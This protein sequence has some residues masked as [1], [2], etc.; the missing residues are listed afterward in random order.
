MLLD[1][2]INFLKDIPPFLFLEP[3]A[4][5]SL[6]AK[7]SLEFY[8]QNTIILKQ[9]GPPSETLLVIKKGGVKV[10]IR[11][12]DGEEVLTDY[13]GEGDLIGYLSLFSGDKSR[14]NVATVED[15][16]CYVISKETIQAL[17]DSEPVI[18][19]FFHKSFVNKYVDKTF[20]EM[21]SKTLMIGGGT[22]TL[23]F[24]T[25]VGELATKGVASVSKEV[26][27]QEAAG[28]M[29]T[30]RIS[31][32]VLT[33]ANTVPV[34][35]LTDRDL[36]DKVVAKGR[37]TSEKVSSIMSPSLIKAE[38]R[39]YCFEALLKMLRHNIHH[40]L[41]VDDG[42]LKGIITN[43]DLMMLQGKSPLSFAKDI[44]SQ[45]T[46]EGLIPVS[47]KV[48]TVVKL[49][50]KEGVRA[51][52]ISKIISELN[53]RVVRKVLEIAEK[54]FGQPPLPYCWIVFGSEGRKEQ[55][56]KTDQ[57]NAIIFA[58]P[59]SPEEKE[60]AKK[61]FHTF[62]GFV[63]D[64]LLKCGFPECPAGN[65]ASNP[66]WCQPLSVWKGYFGDW[67]SR[68][69]PEAVLKSLIFFDFRPLHGDFS[70]AEDLRMQLIKILKDQNIF[71]AKMA[72]VITKNRPPLGFFKTFIVEKSGE[73]KDEVN[74]KIN[75]TGPLVD[76]VRFMT[77]EAGIS[78]T[79]TLE[80]IEKLKDIHPTVRDLGEELANG[81]EFITLL[82]I[83][84]Q[85]ASIEKSGAPDNFLNPNKLSNLEKKMLKEAFQVISK[86]QD[87]IAE[88]YGPGMVGG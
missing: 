75:G 43:H 87:S 39:E 65:M 8:P 47:L 81:F 1:D 46:I 62:A 5:R 30:S 69:T 42:K 79:S 22:D 64:G 33:D 2:T 37:D 35:I 40:L 15:T 17:Y 44:E 52:N 3:E 67:I 25:T 36:R 51:G 59:S 74:L 18:R 32:I 7:M 45:F 48:N 31:S 66:D 58:N 60:K 21:H 82:R 86:A 80:R 38:A 28:I 24:T 83:H 61:Y 12:G 50:L 73:H 77:L 70:L 54:K 68:P 55:T 23:M 9:D 57:D 16:I 85:I 71:M 76:V 41:V 19:E 56:F 63:K 88:Q 11:S 84:H 26:S 10:F 6:A 29:S 72:S 13:R 34:G 53:D 4:I 20:K 27:I 49:L 78:E 14:A